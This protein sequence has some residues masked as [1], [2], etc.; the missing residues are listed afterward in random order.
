MAQITS[1]R[2]REVRWFQ[3]R[4]IGEIHRW[5]NALPPT[6]FTREYREDRYLVLPGRRDLGVKFRENRLE[7]KY[8][9]AAS[10]LQE[11]APGIKGSLESWEKLGF[12]STPETASSLLPEDSTATRVSVL[13]RRLAT[14][15]ET[16]GGQRTFHP[17][18]TPV[19]AGV[20]FEYTELQVRGSDWYTFG[21]EWL[22]NKPVPLPAQLL[23]GLLSPSEF[24]KMYA[25]GYPEF[26]QR[27]LH[28]KGDLGIIPA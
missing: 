28:S 15:I 18:G 27:L 10:G 24:E 26:L 21:L 5:F 3:N 20:Q 2:T 17:L 23:A 14:I 9:L 11:I 25:M 7:L 13:K 4:P 6:S 1:F 16:T 19:T 12:P 8:R 22:E